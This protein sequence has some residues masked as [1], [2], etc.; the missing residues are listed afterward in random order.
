VGP[1]Q[2]QRGHWLVY[3]HDRNRSHPRR[4]PAIKASLLGTADL[5]PR[6]GPDGLIRIWLDCKFVDRLGHMRGPGESYSDV[7]LRVSKESS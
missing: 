5:T 4:A 2:E 1:R 3:S 6:R 7:I